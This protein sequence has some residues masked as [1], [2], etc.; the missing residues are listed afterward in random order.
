VATAANTLSAPARGAATR[1]VRIQPSRGW[2]GVDVRELWSYR[3]LLL[4]LAW[5]DVKVRYK[6]TLLGVGWAL[7]QPLAAMLV[8][9]II[10]GHWVGIPTNLV[11][12]PIFVL[13]GLL[14]WTYFSSCLTLS[15]NSVVANSNLV[16]KVYFPRLLI[17][18]AAVL[19]P[20]VDFLIGFA[21]LL[22]MFV[23]YGMH[24]HWHVSICWIFLLLALTVALGVGFW[25]SA[26]NVR[27]R[28]VPYLLPFLTQ[29]WLYASPVI[30]PVTI[31][32]QRFRWALAL[33]PM[34]GVIDGFRWSVFGK[35]VPQYSVYATSG[36]VAIVLF[37]TG[38]LYFRRVERR[39]A[40]LV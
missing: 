6:Q 18:I 24:P 35:G 12:Y 27:Y 23:Y 25:L 31:V 19:V 34:T 3:E 21:I 33:N 2:L 7:V 22:G 17:P 32:P 11:P 36:G 1:I 37:A 13:G 14:P 8:F 20:I 40:D 10:F 26:L 9:T 28:D 38:L 39:F 15:S 29:L 30:Y 16:S 4:F 5:R